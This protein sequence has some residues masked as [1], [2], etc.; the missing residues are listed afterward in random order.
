MDLNSPMHLCM[1]EFAL[2]EGWVWDDRGTGPEPTHARYSTRH[3]CWVV[4]EY[5]SSGA[6]VGLFLWICQFWLVVD[7]YLLVSGVLLLLL[8][9]SVSEL[10]KPGNTVHSTSVRSL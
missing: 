9:A 10:Q 7:I 3:C 4:R 2:V 6:H 5:R 1:G 8:C